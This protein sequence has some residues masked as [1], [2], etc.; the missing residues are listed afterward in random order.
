MLN[1]SDSAYGIR[2]Q[3]VE[4]S[5]GRKIDHTVVS[6]GRTVVPALNWGVPFVVS[7][8][9]AP[10]SKDVMSLAQEIANRTS[11]GTSAGTRGPD[12]RTQISLRMALR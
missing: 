11:R 10:A 1:R 3:D 12:G 4:K 7:S 6:D 8:K 2:L 5:I 9:Q